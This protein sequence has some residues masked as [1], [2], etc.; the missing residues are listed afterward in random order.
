[1]ANLLGAMGGMG[2][3]MAGAGKMLAF[4]TIVGLAGLII[5]ILVIVIVIKGRQAKVIQI[6]IESRKMLFSNGRTKK[7]KKGTRQ[8]W[9]NKAKKYL[10]TLSG[11][12]FFTKGKRDTAILLKDKNGLL[13]S[14]RIPTY[15]E[16]CK[17]YSVVYGVDLENEEE[18]SNHPQADRLAKLKNVWLLPNPH[19][20]ID[21]LATQSMEANTEF[22]DKAWWQHPNFMILGTVLLCV[23]AWLLTMVITAKQL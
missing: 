11:A 5:G 15:E 21:W 4:I 19:E 3:F 6:D 9:Y 2:G 22:D 1:M 18:I 13:H 23:I 8:F 14:A 20:D 16:I 12:D 10:P 17:W 7:T